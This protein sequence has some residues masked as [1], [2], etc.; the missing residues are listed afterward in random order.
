[1]ILIVMFELWGFWQ[2]GLMPLWVPIVSTV[3]A[4]SKLVSDAYE[5]GKGDR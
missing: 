3:V 1:M 5:K 4:A 2:I